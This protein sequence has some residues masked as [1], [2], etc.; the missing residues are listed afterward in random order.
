MRDYL[1]NKSSL[2]ND[3]EKYEENHMP[4]MHKGTV[5]KINANQVFLPKIH[6]VIMLC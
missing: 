6:F 2:E 4:A 5:I 1:R 3:S